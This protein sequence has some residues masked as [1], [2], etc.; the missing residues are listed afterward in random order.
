MKFGDAL[1]MNEDFAGLIFGLLGFAV[2][3]VFAYFYGLEKNKKERADAERKN[4][5]RQR[6]E[7]ERNQKHRDA[8]IKSAAKEAARIEAVA[9]KEKERIANLKLPAELTLE[10][11]DTRLLEFKQLQHQVS[12]GLLLVL[13]YVV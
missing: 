3:G 10:P 4:Y 12:R 11:I 7:D 13:L 5:D 8:Q 9:A 2:I 1:D 6:K